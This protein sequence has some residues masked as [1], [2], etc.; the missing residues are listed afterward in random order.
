MKT[1]RFILLIV[2]LVASNVIAAQDFRESI[3]HADLIVEGYLKFEDVEKVQSDYR[4]P[5]NTFIVNEVVAGDFKG[6]SLKV[7]S[8]SE[9]V[10]YEY[11][12][13]NPQKYI[14]MLKKAGDH[15]YAINGCEYQTAPLIK[16]MLMIVE[17]MD[18]EERFNSNINWS[19]RV[20]EECTPHETY[21][22]YCLI[23]P[24][25]PFFEYNKKAGLISKPDKVLSKEQKKRILK[26][27]LELQLWE[28]SECEFAQ[29]IYNKFPDE[30]EG[31]I[32]KM[33]EK[34]YQ[35][36]GYM[37]LYAVTRMLEVMEEG[38]KGKEIKALLDNIE[39]QNKKKNLIKNTIKELKEILNK[40]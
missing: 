30:I 33:L 19:I 34:Y 28:S 40:Q 16:E 37:S 7:S 3:I 15:Y 14:Y 12:E 17:I 2:L 10:F 23:A 35:K 25:T 36:D 38:E 5:F 20:L 9:M 26:R 13:E 31:H 4:S 21:I 29:L 11:E 22:N 32:L 24:Y 8:F 39:G 1:R 18:D 27:L 6:D